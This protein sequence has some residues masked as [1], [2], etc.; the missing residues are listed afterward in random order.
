MLHNKFMLRCLAIA[1]KGIGNVSPNPMVGSVV[2]YKEQIIGE[3]FHQ[4]YGQHHAEVNAIHSVKNK[5]LLSESTIYVNLE[6]CSHT[7][8]TPPCADLIIRS[9]IKKVV[10]GAIDTHSKVAGAGIKKLREAGIEVVY[11]VLEKECRTLNKR[12]YCFHEK[13]RP[14][15]ML[16]WAQTMDGF[17]SPDASYD[18]FPFWITDKKT[19][20]LTHSWRAEEDAIL[21]GQKTATL[22]NPSLTC[23]AFSGNNPVRVLIDK[24]LKTPASSH[25][26]NNESPTIVINQIKEATEQ[27]I[28]FVKL[29]DFSI[30]NILEVLY[31]RDIAS[32]MVEGGAY[33]LQQFIDSQ[34][35]DEAKVLTG[36]KLLQKGLKAPLLP[37]NISTQHFFYGK[38]EI[39]INYPV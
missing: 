20:V 25:I 38:D 3:G 37:T 35:W 1:K 9:G 23:R 5:E 10:I 13:K 4:Q 15:V 30:D 22:D 2:V 26:F 29:N 39:S 12:F 14:Y 17:I 8:K 6:P 32:L 27:N 21:I 34:L 11:P 19:K 16:K 36:N 28:T 31:R 7:G 18:N 33:T 24:D